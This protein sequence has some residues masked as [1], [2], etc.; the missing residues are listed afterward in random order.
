M[1]EL[2]EVEVP[3]TLRATTKLLSQLEELLDLDARLAKLR[4]RQAELE[5]AREQVRK[6]VARRVRFGSWKVDDFLIRRVLV[7]LAR[8]STR[9]RRSPRAP[10]RKR[11]FVRT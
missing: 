8:R 3:G 1:S 10:S 11:L 7:N 4:E 2:A 6:Q 9:T 5:Y